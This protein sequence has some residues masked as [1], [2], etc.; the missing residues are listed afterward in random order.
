MRAVKLRF[1]QS[2]ANLRQR[3]NEAIDR[4]TIQRLQTMR[5]RGGRS[6]P[7]LSSC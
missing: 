3:L 4:S 5:M 2:L 7:A 6:V 1:S